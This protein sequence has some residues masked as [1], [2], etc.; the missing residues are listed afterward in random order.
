MKIN[1]NDYKALKALYKSTH[2]KNWPSW[3]QWTGWDFSS[4]TPPDVSVVDQWHGVTVEGSRVTEISLYNS[5]SGTLPSELGS[6]SNLQ[7]LNLN[8]NALSG[9]L[10]SE[11]GSLSNLQSLYLGGNDLNGTLPPELG[12]LSNLQR[13]YLGG[14]DLNGTVRFVLA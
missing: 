11:L 14:N 1:A 8:A 6:L 10:P 2:G 3:S 5:M 4:E 9:A 12:S 13:L 7:I